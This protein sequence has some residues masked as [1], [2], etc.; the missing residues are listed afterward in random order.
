[1]NSLT[2]IDVIEQGDVLVVD[3]RLIADE[4]GVSHESFMK[5]IKKHETKIEQRFGIIRFRIG[6]I[7]GRGRPEK[8]ALL[9][10]PQATTLMTFSRNTDQVVECKLNLVEAFDRAKTAIKNLVTPQPQPRQN[11]F[12]L[13]PES[14]VSTLDLIFKGTSVDPHLV[15]GL[16]ANCVAKEFPALKGLA[17]EAKKFLPLPVEDRLVTV[18]SLAAEYNARHGKQLTA[19]TMNR[20]LLE[21]GFQIKNADKNPCYLTTEKGKQ[22]GKIVL[23]EAKSNNTTVQQL[24]WYMSI[25]E[26]I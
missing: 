18:T 14:I 8:Y 24:R 10:E 26:V 6:E 15:A 11:E 4:L 5:T 13:T 12:I 20:I 16:K 25:L 7:D 2:K 17:E 1:M 23:Q 22:Y 3:S 9:T 19:V 21:R